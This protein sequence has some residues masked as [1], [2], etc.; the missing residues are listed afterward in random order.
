[1]EEYKIVIAED[2]SSTPG[3][4]WER[5]GQ[6]SG[7]A[8]YNN[9]L[10]P[11]FEKAVEN[12]QKLHIYLDGVRSYPYSFLDQ[13]FGELSRVKGLSAVKENIIFHATEKAWVIEYI[14]S[15]V[16]KDEKGQ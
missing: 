3:G 4:R 9:L 16:W 2:F 10:L 6:F 11:Y 5:L 12:S 15:N 13:S 14:N 7:E 8:F 1:M